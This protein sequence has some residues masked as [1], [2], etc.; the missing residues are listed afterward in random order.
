MHVDQIRTFLEIARSGSFQDAADTLNVTQSTV[1]ARIKTLE[2]E[3]NHA[4]FRRTRQGAQLTHAG[5]Q[6]HRY[7]LVIGR[8]WENARAEVQLPQRFRTTFAIAAQVSLWERLILAWLPWM[9]ARATDV[10]IRAEAD[11]SDAI[12]R[13][14]SDGLLDIGVMYQPR[15]VAGLVSELLLQERLVLV[16]TQAQSRHWDWRRNYVYVDWGADF[17]EDH[18]NVWPDLATP[19]LTFGLGEMGLRYILEHGGAGYFPLRVVR[20]LLREGSLHRVRRA[21]VMQR[22]AY[23]VY[24]AVWAEEELL[25]LALQGL[26]E[27]VG[28]EPE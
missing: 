15:Q 27:I 14:L 6:L 2:Q 12:M 20:P 25:Q 11:Y 8:A 13:H 17:A 22:P 10:A 5:Q 3:M 28:R 19:A 9:R 4:L 16:S 26:Y 18:A 21:P 24:P 23:V 1:S 7:A